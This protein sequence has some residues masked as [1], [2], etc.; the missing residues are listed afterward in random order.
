L[1]ERPRTLRMIQAPISTAPGSPLVKQIYSSDASARREHA[2]SITTVGTPAPLTRALEATCGGGVISARE[3]ANPR[4]AV[5]RT[6]RQHNNA[7]REGTPLAFDSASGNPRNDQPLED[8]RQ[9]E[10]RQH[11]Q[12]A[13]G[14]HEHRSRGQVVYEASNND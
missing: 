3:L 14:V 2:R 8:Q 6:T 12:H 10:W 9:H 1:Y 11:R 4:H 7:A 13:A 5:A